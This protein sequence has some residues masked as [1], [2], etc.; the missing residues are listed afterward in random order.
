MDSAA[1][2]R[3]AAQALNTDLLHQCLYLLRHPDSQLLGATWSIYQPGFTL[4]VQGAAFALL[5]GI[6]IWLV[7]LGLWH[8]TA[9][10]A[11]LA[12]RGRSPASRDSRSRTAA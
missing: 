8:G 2:L 3:A 12:R 1:R 4:T 5:L 10:A 9:G 6:G 11:R 7:F